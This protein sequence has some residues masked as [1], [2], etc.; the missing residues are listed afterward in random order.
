MIQPERHAADAVPIVLM[1][2]EAR[3]ADIV[4]ALAEIDQ[5]EIIQQPTR[6]IRVENDLG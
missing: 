5:L 2:H 4:K 6:L 1:T 3:E